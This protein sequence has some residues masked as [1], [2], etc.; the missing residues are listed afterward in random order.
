LLVVLFAKAGTVV[1]NECGGSE[2]QRATPRQ[3]GKGTAPG[4]FVPSHWTADLVN[5]HTQVI[6]E[7]LH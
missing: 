5:V 6:P 3:H 1:R 7:R 4:L 2:K